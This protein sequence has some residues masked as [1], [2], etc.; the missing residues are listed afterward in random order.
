[1]EYNSGLIN[2]I[3]LDDGYTA[4]H[5]TATMDYC[6]MVCYIASMVNTV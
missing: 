4:L 2:Q 3:K 1:M 6:D 5:I